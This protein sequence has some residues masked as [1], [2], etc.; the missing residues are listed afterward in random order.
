MIIVTSAIATVEKAAATILAVDVTRN[1]FPQI[2]PQDG[3]RSVQHFRRE[4][5]GNLASNNKSET[6]ARPQLQCKASDPA[7]VEGANGHCKLLCSPQLCG[8]EQQM[9]AHL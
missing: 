7:A 1:G 3:K 8:S 9:R 6:S 4:F 5:S 2:A